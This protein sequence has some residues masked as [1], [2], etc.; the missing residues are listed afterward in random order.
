VSANLTQN[1]FQTIQ[2]VMMVLSWAIDLA[3]IADGVERGLTER[4]SQL[5]PKHLPNDPASNDG[6]LLGD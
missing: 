3:G 6:S 5:N 2:Q 4:V 1:T